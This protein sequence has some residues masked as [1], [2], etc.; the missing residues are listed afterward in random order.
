MSDLGEALEQALAANPD[1]L[2][3][4]RAYAD[5]LQEQSDP[6]LAARGEL[7]GV[8]LQLEESAVTDEERKALQ[9]REIELLAQHRRAWLGELAPFL[10]DSRLQ[11]HRYHASVADG[12][13]HC[14]WYSHGTGWVDCERNFTMAR[15]WLDTVEVG[16]LTV[17]FS[18]VFARAP[19]TRLLRRLVIH[20]CRRE[21]PGQY[22]PGKDVPER[23]EFVGAY[24]L[25][26]WPYATNLRSLS[27]LGATAEQPV[28]A[29]KLLGRMHSLQEL[30]LADARI[31]FG[32]LCAIAALKDLR[33]LE[34]NKQYGSLY[35]LE[36]LAG[37]RHFDQLAELHLQP[38]SDLID[39]LPL[40]QTSALIRSRR[41]PGL[42]C[43]RMHLYEKGDGLCEVIAGSG[44]LA[45]LEVLELC[46]GFITERGA[47]ALA[48]C[49]DLKHLK[50]LDVTHNRISPE[51][52]AEL[53][54]S[55][56]EVISKCQSDPSIRENWGWADEEPELE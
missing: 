51:G 24:P 55:G 32:D 6:L 29:L 15:G 21:R 25:L 20:G 33:K 16:I 30:C 41:L 1:D 53:R 26:A 19:Q 14:F 9:Q 34:V 49:P 2:A 28:A 7:S 40:T 38:D 50:Q 39:P 56:I 13:E 3:A 37:N 42:K 48:R 44:I 47:R 11:P 18:R 36:A 5:Y 43:L 23:E 46:H 10:L 27:L 22:A 8:Q 35:D 54:K 45:R 12:L 31:R 17:E 4:H 52:I